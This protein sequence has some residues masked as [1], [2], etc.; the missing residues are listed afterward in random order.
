M[1]KIAIFISGTG[2]LLNSFAESSQLEIVKVI[3]NRECVGLEV[4][5]ILGLA[6]EVRS[7]FGSNLAEELN[8]IGVQ[9]VVLAELFRLS[10]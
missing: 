8:L 3:A 9:V 5:E 7:E 4:A 1:K 2:S 6:T 10:F